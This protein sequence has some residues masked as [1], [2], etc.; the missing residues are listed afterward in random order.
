MN[1]Y[2]NITTK[3]KYENSKNEIKKIAIFAGEYGKR[4]Y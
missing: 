1:Y 4:L 2:K 3:N